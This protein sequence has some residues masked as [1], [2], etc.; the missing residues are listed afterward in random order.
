MSVGPPSAQCTMWWPSH[1]PGGRSQ[2][3]N[4]Q[5]RSRRVSARRWAGVTARA[6]RPTSMGSLRPP[7]TTGM[8]RASQASRRT[9]SAGDGFAGLVDMPAAGRVGEVV[10][11]DRDRDGGPARF[12]ADG[13]A[14]DFGERGGP[15][16]RGGAGRAARGPFG[17][18]EPFVLGVDGG[19]DHGAVLARIHAVEHG[20]AVERRRHMQ[21]VALAPLAL[22]TVGV[23]LQQP[24]PQ[25][26]RRLID[27][28]ATGMVD[29]HR[30]VLARTPRS[31]CRCDARPTRAAPPSRTRARRSTTRP[32]CPASTATVA[33]C[34]P[35]SPPTTGSAHTDTP[36]TPPP[37]S[38]R[39]MPTR[40]EHQPRRPSHRRLDPTPF[41]SS[42]HVAASAASSTTQD[43]P[44]TP[45]PHAPSS[46][47]STISI[48]GKTHHRGV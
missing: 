14:D 28:Q 44:P 19:L 45:R 33:P 48:K 20:G 43:R 37:T 15:A 11:T 1:Q 5:P 32:R 36:T 6:A 13:P 47:H 22:L 9:V 12:G 35:A 39:R 40:H 8:M 46:R 42:P 2:P 29:E 18:P 10:E 26:Q 7:S 4:T 31:S 3:G 24:V 17:S 30:L 23:G 25:H 38:H 16:L 34:A 41:A 27:G 21:P